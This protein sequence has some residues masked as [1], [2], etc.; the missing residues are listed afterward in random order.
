MRWPKI[1]WKKTPAAR[2]DKI[3]GPTKGSAGGACSRSV[4][5]LPARSTAARICASLGNVDGIAG[6]ECFHRTE[7]HAVG[8]LA[9]GG[10]HEARE[11]PARFD[12]SAFGGHQ[13]GHHALRF[14]C[15]IGVDGSR[16][17]R[18]FG[19]NFA[20]ARGPFGRS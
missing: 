16:I 12:A 15:D 1:S 20:Q 2:P 8:G 5:F 4:R 14:H 18:H 6:L 7:I 17:L 3:A 11:Q 10:D 9:A 19:R 13:R